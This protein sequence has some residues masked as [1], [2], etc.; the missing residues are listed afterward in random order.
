[1]CLALYLLCPANYISIFS[2]YEFMHLHGGPPMTANLADG[3]DWKDQAVELR[4]DYGRRHVG[5]GLQT[6][7]GGN[8]L[9]SVCISSLE[10]SLS[11]AGVHRM[12]RQNGPKANTGA[13]F[14]AYAYM[15]NPGE[16]RSHPVAQRV[17]H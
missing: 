11:G 10:S 17:Y 9:R 16:P 7:I 1:V 6:L 3:H 5:T 2:S 14:L 12:W 4:Q 13:L 15:R 8:H